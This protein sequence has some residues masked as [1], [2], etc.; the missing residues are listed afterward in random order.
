M[1]KERTAGCASLSRAVAGNG[2]G[3][4]SGH[5]GTRSP[6]LMRRL[7]KPRA[8]AGKSQER[9]SGFMGVVFSSEVQGARLGTGAE[10]DLGWAWS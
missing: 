10:G 2:K 7:A 5:A 1:E 3:G 6:F 8:S 4:N 9:S